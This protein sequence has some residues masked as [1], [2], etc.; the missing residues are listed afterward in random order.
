MKV[1]ASN[2]LTMT[3]VLIALNAIMLCKADTSINT[4]VNTDGISNHLAGVL[5][6][7]KALMDTSQPSYVCAS[8]FCQP[9][10]LS[11]FG[12]TTGIISSMIYFAG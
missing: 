1:S 9:I 3:L 8:A 4:A 6:H 10:A 12:F 11:V 5:S 2:A 7:A